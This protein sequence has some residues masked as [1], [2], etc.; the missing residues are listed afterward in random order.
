MPTKAPEPTR[1]LTVRIPPEAAGRLDRALARE[2]TGAHSRS[3]LARLIREGRVRIGGAPAKPATEVRGGDVVVIELPEPE[4]SDLI[5]EDLPVGVLWEDDRLAV[6]DKPA[7][8]VTHPAGPLRT[9]TLVNAL[10]FRL[11]GLSGVGGVLRPGIVHR[12]DKGTSGLLVVAKDDETHRRLADQLRDRTLSRTYDAIAW[13]RV[14]P[15]GFT[16]DAPIGRHPRDRK[17]MAVVEGG[18]AAR[19][20][21]TVRSASD[22]ASRLEVRLETGRTHQIRVH[23]RHQGHPIVGDGTYGGRRQS[24]RRVPAHLRGDA[25]RLLGRIDRPAL[26]SRKLELTHPFTGDR[27]R[28]ESP[29]PADFRG[30]LDLVEAREGRPPQEPEIS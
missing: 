23:L 11:G 29:P 25:E 5:P 16:V 18:R 3:E 10:L 8:M 4:P 20:H 17:R 1:R 26:H 27:I 24:L 12:L 9:G 21:V 19:S 22:L 30:L 7:G 2:L 6:V 15:R 13:G 28:V 14:A